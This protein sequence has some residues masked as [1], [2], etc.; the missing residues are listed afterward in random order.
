MRAYEKEPTRIVGREEVTLLRTLLPLR[1][2]DA[3][4]EYGT[5]VKSRVLLGKGTPPIH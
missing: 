2:K 4:W 3:V 1:W 5:P